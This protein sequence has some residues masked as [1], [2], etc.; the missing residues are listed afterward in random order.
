MSIEK[1]EMLNIIAPK[2]KMEN[3]LRELVVLEK[4][5]I[6]NA[7]KDVTEGNFTIE[8]L[9]DNIKMLEEKCEITPYR[10]FRIN[11]KPYMDKLDFLEKGLGLELRNMIKD[12]KVDYELKSDFESIDLIYEK[13][14]EIIDEKTRI[15]Q[16]I[17][18]LKSFL[19]S[20]K[21]LKGVEFSLETL[22][23]MRYFTC[24]LGSIS[25]EKK[26][27]LRSNYENISAV[28]IHVGSNEKEEVYLIVTPK[29]LEKETSRLLKSLDFKEV[30]RGNR[31]K[32]Y[33]EAVFERALDEIRAKEKELESIEGEIIDI[34]RAYEKDLKKIYW[35]VAMEDELS[36]LRY[37]LAET[38]NFYYFS[39]WAPKK[40]TSEIIRKLEEIDKS[41]IVE[42]KKQ[43]DVAKKI[44][45]PTS[46]KNNWLFRPFE[47]MVKMYG[48]PNYKEKDPTVFLSITYLIMFGAMFGDLGQGFVIFLLG[49]YA[50]KSKE[51]K[52]YG[53]ILSR[54]GISSMIF[55]ILFGSVFGFEEVIPALWIRPIESIS[56][57]LKASIA[58]GISLLLFSFG[59]S[60]YNNMNLKN[61]KEG[62]FGRNGIAG[63]CFYSLILVLG[64][65]TFLKETWIHPYLGIGFISLTIVLMVFRKPLSDIFA[66]N[67]PQYEEGRKEYY[68]ES[69]FDLIETIL[70]LASNTISFIRIGAFAL[71][72]VG[73]FVAFM[74]MARMINNSVGGVLV[75]IVGNIIIIGLEGLIVFIQGLRLEYYELF[76]KYF[77]GDGIEYSPVHLKYEAEGKK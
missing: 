70:S 76:S 21:Y 49:K 14:Y 50:V 53:E 65:Q 77:I 44:I 31:F 42:V 5:H 47:L 19:E 46:L 30:D 11:L 17:T 13:V 8:V 45:P 28:V 63:L 20:I 36:R 73:L 51:M 24:H 7:Y 59:I 71:N 64:T 62:V 67:K 2:E 9:E 54:L 18:D 6:G 75:I 55:G 37:S 32:G 33:P 12:F 29:Y 48:I 60:I 3:I 16:E 57:V 72:H 66:G 74:T 22:D 34:R 58:F 38:D 61:Y 52:P 25:K 15:I 4:I 43:E 69:G 39:G 1:M 68:I 27:K 35:H 40:D 23:D 41:V 10:G 26:T 56:F